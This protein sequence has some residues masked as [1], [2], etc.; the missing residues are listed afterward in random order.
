MAE[1]VESAI[2]YRAEKLTQECEQLRKAY[3]LEERCHVAY[4]RDWL[5]PSRGMIELS[6]QI[7]RCDADVVFY[8]NLL[9]D[10]HAGETTLP[11][12]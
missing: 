11:N 4:D 1:K 7:M 12:R 3:D 9:T 8:H 2:R 6:A 5:H 10:L